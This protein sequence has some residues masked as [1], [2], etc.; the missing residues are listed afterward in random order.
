MRY[1]AWVEAVLRAVLDGVD[2]PY[3]FGMPQVGTTLGLDMGNWG[4][5]DHRELHI[6]I[7]DAIDDLDAMGLLSST[8][9]KSLAAVPEARRYKVHPLSERWPELRAGYLEPDEERYLAR[10]EAKVGDTARERVT[11]DAC[12]SS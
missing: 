1:A 10:D 12:G 8:G 3:M 11:A 7:S 5:A 9:V 6:A 4:D 2:T